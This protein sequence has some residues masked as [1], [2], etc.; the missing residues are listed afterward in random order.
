MQVVVYAIGGSKLVGSMLLKKD[1]RASL[2][3]PSPTSEALVDIG[4]RVIEETAEAR[5]HHPA[6][7]SAINRLHPC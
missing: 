1:V 5:A 3:A 2:L 4:E 7:G 6:L